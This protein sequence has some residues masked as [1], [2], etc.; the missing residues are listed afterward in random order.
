MTSKQLSARRRNDQYRSAT[1]T[2]AVS[3]IGVAAVALVALVVGTFAG[4]GVARLGGGSDQSASAPAAVVAPKAT[5]SVAAGPSR[6]EGMV[7]VG[8][9]HNEA[10]ALAAAQAYTAMTTEMLFRPEADARAAARMMATANSADL[11]E[12]ATMAP[13]NGIRQ[14]LAVAANQNPNGRALVRTVPIGSRTVSYSG[15]RA[16]IDVWSM[17]LIGLEIDVNAAQGGAPTRAAFTTTSFVLEWANGD[18]RVADFKRVDDSGPAMSRQGPA[19]VT[20]FIDQAST[21][22][23]FRYQPNRGAR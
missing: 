1:E 21:F 14:S 2:P 6:F 16:R 15:E 22:T 23:P 10:G 7:P 3:K 13:I 8:Y 18:W 11:V 20:D 9:L 12:A 17:T 5:Q 4:S 19:K